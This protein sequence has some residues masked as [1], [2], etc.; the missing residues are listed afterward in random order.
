MWD[1]LKKKL[2]DTAEYHSIISSV[3]DGRTPVAVSRL[4]GGARSLFVSTMLDD[5][6]EPIMIVVPDIVRLEE[7]I[8][9]LEAFGVEEITAYYEDEMLCYD[10]GEPDRDIVGQQM[11]ALSGLLQNRSK[12]FV[13]TFR[14]IVKKVMPPETLR[15]LVLKVVRGEERDLTQLEEELVRLGYERHTII[16]E[17]GQFAVRGGIID[18]FEITRT[19][20][21]RIEFDGD[22]AVSIRTFDIETQISTEDIEGIDIHPARNF[23]VSPGGTRRL[24]EW[25]EVEAEGLDEEARSRASTVADRFERGISFFGMENYAALFHDLVPIYEY[26][27]ER[28]V[29]IIDEYEAFAKAL[30]EYEER[31]EERFARSR[32]E[33]HIYPEPSKVYLSKDHVTRWLSSAKEMRLLELAR[34]EAISFDTSPI[35]DYRR[36]LKGL[37]RD[38]SK[39]VRKGRRVYFFCANEVQSGRIE[40]LLEDVAIEVD[41][42]V[43]NLS[44]GF[45]WDRLGVMFLSEREVF[46]RYGRLAVFPRS[47]RRTLMYDPSHF[48]PGDFV[49]HVNH[50]IGR[51]MGLKVIDVKGGKRECLD[52]RYDG[53]DHLFIPVNQLRMIEKYL[54]AEGAAPSL[55]RLGAGSWAKRKRRAQKSAELVAKDLLEIYAARQLAEGHAFEPDKPWQKEMEASFPYEETPHQLQATDE[56]KADMEKPKPMDRLLCGDV[57]FGKTE[58]AI[59]AAFKAVLSGKQCAFLVPTTVLALQHYNTLSD[60]LRGYPVRVEMLSRFISKGEQKS[61]I[62]DI[63]K[64]AVDIVVGTHRLLSKDIVFADLGLLVVDE[65]HRFGVRQKET[66]KRLKRNVDVLSMTATP[67]PRTLSMALSGIRDLSVIDTPPRNRLPIHTEIIDFDDETIRDAILREVQR[68]GQVFFVHNRVQ[69]IDVIA[70][71]LR[72]LLPDSIGISVAHG[73]MREK[74]LE[75]RMIEV[76]E[77]KSD[78]LV[79]TMIIEAGLDFPNVNTI[80]VDKADHFGLAQLYQLRGR[81]GRSDRQAYAYLIVSSPQSL[82]SE[83]VKRLQAIS[84]FDYLG[85]GYHIAMKDLEIR[86]AGNLLGT[87][88]SGHISAVG[89][90][91]YTNMLKEEVAKLK[92]ETVKKV[93]EVKVSIPVSA[94]IPHWYVVDTE[95]RMD[96]YRRLARLEDAEEIEGIRA[97]LGDRFGPLPLQ[98]DLMLRF[99]AIKHIAGRL[100]VEKIESKKADRVFVRFV[101]GFNPPRPLIARLAT[102]YESRITFDV[103]REFS[104]KIRFGPT[105]SSGSMHGSEPLAEMGARGTGPN[106][107]EGYGEEIVEKIEN[108]LKILEFYGR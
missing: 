103:R 80:I 20:P 26:V 9:D 107:E 104:F 90:D 78:V 61:I 5:V 98:A 63:A 33:G 84:E 72:R 15:S 108:L 18:I 94:Y 23:V 68:G 16:E 59:R 71:Y 89:L 95:E 6:T 30:D 81:V 45:K 28:P 97:E 31:I 74:E 29:V 66:L 58:V 22:E 99:V 105:D 54:S 69:S 46:G 53:N 55:D 13:C 44:E 67:I 52:I 10:F 87:A 32:S 62:A 64:G 92:G 43:G 83:A 14:S 8:E 25:I 7:T 27:S 41:I 40:E 12:V 11:K 39:E 47:R 93:G 24:R 50:G 75:E 91:L 35:G 38:I 51:Y 100:K 96:I 60:R 21:V 102:E 17:K 70:G 34:S 36:N 101:K 77:H 65:E 3:Q 37:V 1:E 73:Q 49:V 85:A 48:E 82:T 57:G 2:R 79:C 42:P 56:V 86:G 106:G 19:D 76:L 88:Q 4:V